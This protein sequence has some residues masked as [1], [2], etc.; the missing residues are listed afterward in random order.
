MD[1]VTALSAFYHS[2]SMEK[3]IANYD[4]SLEGQ[5]VADLMQRI[6]CKDGGYSGGGIILGKIGIMLI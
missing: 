3:I 4:F 1:M 2:Q 6:V 5:T